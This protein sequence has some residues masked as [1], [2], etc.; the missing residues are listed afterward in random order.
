VKR[1]VALLSFLVA[2]VLLGMALSC[3][4]EEG[5]EAPRKWE[6]IADLRREGYSSVPG[7]IQSHP[8]APHFIAKVALAGVVFLMAGGALWG[9]SALPRKPLAR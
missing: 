3:Y 5:K 7:K 6:G 4:L 2:L 9:P 8:D 1:T